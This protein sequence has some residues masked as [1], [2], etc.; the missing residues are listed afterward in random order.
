MAR[1]GRIKRRPEED[2]ELN[3]VPIMNMF[4][5]LIPFLLMSASFIHIK[6]INTSVPVH[7]DT[8]KKNAEKDADVK[9]TV[10]LALGETELNV[11]AT[12]SGLTAAQLSALE[13]SIPLKGGLETVEGRLKE[14]L[15]TIKTSYPG[16]DTIVLVPD[17]SILYDDI[18]RTMDMA[19]N[20]DQSDLFPNV[21]LSGSL[22]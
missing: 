13:A 18:I 8:S 6:A 9:V 2:T 14:T 1:N 17:A 3:M 15:K 19:R 5:V 22:G 4:M 11:T 20:I 12:A 10:M 21:V 16:S 7:A